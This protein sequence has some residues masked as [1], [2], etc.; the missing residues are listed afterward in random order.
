[1][2]LERSVCDLVKKHW[3]DLHPNRQAPDSLV[4]L[5]VA[6]KTSPNAA[7]IAMILD[8]SIQRP[9]AI[10]L[11]VPHTLKIPVPHVLGVLLTGGGR[12][13]VIHIECGIA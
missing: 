6:G 11:Q 13:A 8:A 4:F 10:L 2:S 5:K 9:V 12:V 7:I 1:M 3:V